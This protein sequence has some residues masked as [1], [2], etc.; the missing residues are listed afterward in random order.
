MLLELSEV[1][2]KDKEMAFIMMMMIHWI[3]AWTECC[4]LLL[5]VPLTFFFFFLHPNFLKGEKKKLFS[6]Q[7]LDLIGLIW[8][9]KMLPSMSPLT[10]GLCWFSSLQ[11]QFGKFL[12]S[13][14]KFLYFLLTLTYIL[15]ILTTGLLQNLP[16]LGFLK[17]IFYR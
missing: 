3:T 6:R 1:I 14:P 7:R 16:I 5:L 4:L 15:T 2:Y 10:L 13:N 17:L 8:K 11:L 9:L 12:L